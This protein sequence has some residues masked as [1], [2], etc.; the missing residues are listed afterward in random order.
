M[1]TG[2]STELAAEAS[3]RQPGGGFA[4]LLRIVSLIATGAGAVGSVGL[5]IWIGHRNPS[6]VLLSLFVIWDLSPFIG[7]VLA[8]IL[9]RRWSRLVRV[10]LYLLMLIIT[11]GSLVLYGDVVLRPR[12][13]PAFRFLIVPLASWLLLMTV[14]SIGVL[15]GRQSRRNADA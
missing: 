3:S 5:M 4:G 11:L 2:G 12:P 7:L 13:Q 6:L 14:V 9:S 15:S 1:R 10:A 8:D